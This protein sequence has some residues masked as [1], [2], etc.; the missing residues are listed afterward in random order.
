MA[1]NTQLYYKLVQFK[2]NIWKSLHTCTAVCTDMTDRIKKSKSKSVTWNL[3]YIYKLYYL[4][5]VFIYNYVYDAS[6]AYFSIAATTI[7][8][9]LASSDTLICT[10]SA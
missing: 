3:N 5:C 7:S 4:L 9:R 8:S 10:S 6:G 2:N 1:E